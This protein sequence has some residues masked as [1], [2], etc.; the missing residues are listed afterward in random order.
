MT[1]ESLQEALLENQDLVQ[2]AI[3]E[4]ADA[5]VEAAVE[6]RVR[7]PARL[8]ARAY[9]YNVCRACVEERDILLLTNL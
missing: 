5:L 3:R 9:M 7:Y 2:D 8:R 6:E 1:R 4:Q